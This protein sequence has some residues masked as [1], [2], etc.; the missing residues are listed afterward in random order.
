[1]GRAQNQTDANLQ[2]ERASDFYAD[3]DF[4]AD[5][6]GAL[7]QMCDNERHLNPPL[8]EEL[9][10]IFLRASCLHELIDGCRVRHPMS[11]VVAFGFLNTSLPAEE[12]AFQTSPLSFA[13]IRSTA[14]KIVHFALLRK[15]V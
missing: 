2:P 15:H 10:Y 9:G 7:Q 3:G 13:F 1:M 12:P 8:D 6:D 11:K 14:S 5:M 4:Y